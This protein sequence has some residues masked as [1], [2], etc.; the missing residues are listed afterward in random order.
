MGTGTKGVVRSLAVSKLGLG[1]LSAAGKK[2]PCPGSH[3]LNVFTTMCAK[4]GLTYGC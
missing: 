2:Q 4:S 3:L 1:D